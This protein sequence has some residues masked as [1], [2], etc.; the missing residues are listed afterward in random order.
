EDGGEAAETLTFS[1]VSDA[2]Q[3]QRLANIELRRRRAGGTINV[4]MNFLGYNC[5]PGRAVR[6][7]LPSLNIQGEFIVTNWSM[8]A[9]EGCTASLQQ[10]DA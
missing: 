7:N 4:P 10:Y 1:Y 5:R 6:V 3:A 9:N 8:G 2:Y